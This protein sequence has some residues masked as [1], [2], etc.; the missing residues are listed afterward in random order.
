[1][2]RTRVH[3][4]IATR[5]DVAKEA[6]TS[7][8]T[9]HRVLSGRTDI[10]IA[11]ATRKRVL[12]AA[13]RLGYRP[14]PAAR[15][16]KNGRTGILGF[17]M[18][19]QYSKYRGQVLDTMR[20]VVSGTD[21]TMV[22]TDVDEAYYFDRQFDRALRVPV[23]GIIAFDNSGS[24]DAF[25][26]EYDAL[27]LSIPFVS[28]GAYWSESHSHVAVDLGAG[29]RSAVDHLFEVGRRRIAYMAPWNSNLL[30]AGPRY[31]S[32]AQR[33][34]ELNLPIQTISLLDASGPGLAAML[35][36]L[37]EKRIMPEAVICMNDDFAISLSFALQRFGLRPGRDVAVIGFDGIVE[38]NLCPV[39]VTTVRQPIE[40]MCALACQFLIEQTKD[41]NLP[42]QK[43]VLKPELVIRE[44]SMT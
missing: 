9:V 36:E 38:T 1:M 31:E 26:S 25:A 24:V 19:L 14:N 17:W 32:Y 44:S 2:K 21:L 34:A 11:N 3:S 37:A 40:E 42:L 33:M 27:S 16:L 41:P 8:A 4:G 15:A 5:D 6:N 20:S 7:G 18:D 28:M 39:P 23:D 35:S 13:N 22:V 43:R 10:P 30:T 29:M 12:A